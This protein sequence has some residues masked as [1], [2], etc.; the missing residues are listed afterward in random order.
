MDGLTVRVK[1]S[2]YERACRAVTAQRVVNQQH[3]SIADSLSPAF[4]DGL[5]PYVLVNIGSGV[6]LI[7]VDSPCKYKR[8]SGTSLGGGTFWGLC[9]LLTGVKSFDEMLE[10]SMQGDNTTVRRIPDM[11]VSQS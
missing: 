9:K 2:L 11:H 10:L 6:S 5:Y 7:K 4:A 1:G 3:M 8:V